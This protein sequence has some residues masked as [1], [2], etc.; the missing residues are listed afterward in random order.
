VIGIAMCAA[1]AAGLLATGLLGLPLVAIVVSLLSL[2]SGVAVTTPPTTSLAL[3]D[4]PRLAGTASSLLGLARFALGGLAAPLVGIAGADA[5]L[6]LG[7][8]TAVSVALAVITHLTLLRG[9]ATGPPPRPAG[10][11]ALS[12]EGT[13]GTGGERLD[14]LDAGPV[15]V[16]VLDRAG[17]GPSPTPSV[18]PIPHPHHTRRTPC[19]PST[20]MPLR[21]RPRRWS[22]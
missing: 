17:P 11:Q 8:V 16:E 2:V 3:Q 1:G 15:A 6:P 19:A 10:D 5:V 9:P 14:D 20:P 12:P 22:R 21:P 13:A 7:V 4:H 18:Q